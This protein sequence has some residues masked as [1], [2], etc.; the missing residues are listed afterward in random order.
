MASIACSQGRTS[1]REEGEH[2]VSHQVDGLSH[3][4]NIATGFQAIDAVR[5]DRSRITAGQYFS[6]HQVL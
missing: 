3:R 1:F 2:M 6:L 4:T 5:K